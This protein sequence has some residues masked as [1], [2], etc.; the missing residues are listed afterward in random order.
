DYR[1]TITN[2][3]TAQVIVDGET[4]VSL[5]GTTTNFNA[6]SQVLSGSCPATHTTT[7]TI[8]EQ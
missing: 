7:I 2:S 8:V 3:D 6:N 5:A 1:I 4:F